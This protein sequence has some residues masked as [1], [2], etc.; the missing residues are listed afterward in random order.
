[1]RPVLTFRFDETKPTSMV[2]FNLLGNP[3]AHLPLSNF[4]LQSF[5]TPVTGFGGGPGAPTGQAAQWD[6]RD[7]YGE[8]VAGGLYFVVLKGANGTQVLKFTILN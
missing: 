2:I 5:Q 6:G 8:V 3:V 7:D 4:F 1:L